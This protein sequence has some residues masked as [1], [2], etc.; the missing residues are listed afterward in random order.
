MIANQAAPIIGLVF[1]VLAATFDRGELPIVFG[2]RDGHVRGKALP[3][4]AIDLSAERGIAIETGPWAS[5]LERLRNRSF[6]IR[7]IT[8]KI[9][10]IF[11]I[12]RPIPFMFLRQI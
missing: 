9:S 12:L 3:G 4:A 1:V 2:N 7:A 6:E 10:P 5:I 11:I 8:R